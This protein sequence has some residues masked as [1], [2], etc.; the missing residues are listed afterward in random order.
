MELTI[1]E[2]HD[3]LRAGRT[4]CARTVSD[5]LARIALYNP[6][7]RALITIT[8]HALD[9]AQRKDRDGLPHPLPPLHGVP[10]IL[11]DTY[12][13]ACMPTT[14]GVRALRALTTKIDAPV[15]QRLLAAG[16]ILL[17]KANLHE[18][19][20]EGVTLSSLGGQTLNPYD[21]SRTPGGSSGGTAA[22]LAANFALVGCG[23]DT[24]NSMRSPAS[25][26]SVVGLRPSKGRVEG[27]GIMPVSWTQDVAGPMART[28][29]DVRVL[30]DVMK[31]PEEGLSSIPEPVSIPVHI[32]L[33]LPLKPPVADT[34]TNPVY[35]IGILTDYFP[36]ETTPDGPIVLQT[37][38][39]ALH[40]VTSKT[41]NRIQFV[42]L[43]HQPTWDVAR[44]R[45]EADTQ[46][47]EF[48]TA[49]D[50]FLN[51]SIVEYTPHRSLKDV[52]SS[53]EFCEEAVTPA[54]WE[55]QQGQ[56]QQDQ[57]EKCENDKQKDEFTPTSPQYHTRLSIIASLKESVSSCFDALDLSAIVY[58]HQ[59]QLVARVGETV[60][61]G[62]N[63]ILA[64]LVGWPA[65]CIPGVPI[66]LELMGRFGQDEWILELGEVFE[67]IVNGRKAPL[68]EGVGGLCRE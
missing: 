38:T 24:V 42:P 54:F 4:T 66:G 8:P 62:R 6:T 33:P 47:F 25:A 40:L 46:A 56:S 9:D 22:A 61:P 29:R 44:L 18:F 15:V 23:G 50:E 53:G 36:N 51:S 20:L 43:P 12:A 28:V 58:P 3:A 63:G 45:A 48:R 68:L 34:N 59:R 64:A 21:L 30:F 5:Y 52:T 67:G 32:P 55:T 17:A 13:T 2:Y 11:K 49:M 41:S 57:K 31:N 35:K 16:A 39:Q 27:T 65:V 60:Q 10:V 26:C 37:I 7:L 1:A 19:S 14:S